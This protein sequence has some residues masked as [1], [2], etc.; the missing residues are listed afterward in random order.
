MA[1]TGNPSFL[2]EI[3]NPCIAAALT[4]D[5]STLTST[6]IELDI[7]ETRAN[8]I[9][10]PLSVTSSEAIFT[11]LTNLVF[12]VTDASENTP[13]STIFTFDGN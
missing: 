12:T 7:G 10:D 1:S 5:P 13:D 8:E 11:C 2:I 9:A 6:N 3:I 4:I